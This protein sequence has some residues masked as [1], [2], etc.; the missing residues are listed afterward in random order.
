MVVKEGVK[1]SCENNPIRTEVE[2]ENLFSTWMTDESAHPY[3]H[4]VFH[5][6]A[7]RHTRHVRP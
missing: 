3:Y 1:S 6:S 2:Q 4:W 7:G 5:C